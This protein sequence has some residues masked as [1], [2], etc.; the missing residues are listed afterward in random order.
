MNC[1]KCGSII[2]NGQKFCPNC[3][4]PVTPPTD[5]APGQ[6]APIPQ[7]T[8]G[9]FNPGPAPASPAGFAPQP[10]YPQPAPKKP[11]TGLIVLIVVIAVFVLLIAGAIILTGVLRYV[12]RRDS[13]HPNYEIEVDPDIDVD[14]DIDL[15]SLNDA[16]DDL[17]DLDFDDFDDPEV[18]NDSDD[19]DDPE[20]FD[21][22]D[23]DS[24]FRD[25]GEEPAGDKTV[26]SYTDV[27]RN[28]NDITVIPNGGLDADTELF[29]GK[30][31]DGFLDYV[32]S[33]VLEKGRTINRDF[34]YDLLAI[35]LVD[36]NLGSDSSYIEKNLMMAL[37]VANNFHDMDVTI[38]QC[39]LD[40]N[41][42]AEYRLEVTANGKDDIWLINFQQR[43]IYFNN[44]K[45]EYS[46][47][48]FRDDYL[49][50]WLTAIEEY[51]GIR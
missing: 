44:G 9:G 22:S 49:A 29:S 41:N 17:N 4:T 12:A 5:S 30:D 36:E 14:A 10:G 8:P 1:T 38:K 2:E 35:V 37:A 25:I 46:S 7:G 28:G 48:L 31:L 20:D 16:I 18:F 42:A 13:S 45:T 32:D 6:P 19:F 43:T 24:D 26:Y 11:K 15:D 23:T 51:Y 34:F 47:D 21:D 39:G 3:G 33:T 50:V 40:A 27:Y